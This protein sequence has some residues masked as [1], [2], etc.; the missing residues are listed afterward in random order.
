MIRSR[1]SFQSSDCEQIAPI[2]LYK[3]LTVKK[4]RICAHWIILCKKLISYKVYQ[5]NDKKVIVKL[6]EAFENMIV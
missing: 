1:H 5:G 2:A 3:R 6:K 4:T